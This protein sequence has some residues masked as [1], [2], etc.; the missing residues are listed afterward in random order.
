MYVAMDTQSERWELRRGLLFAPLTIS[1]E[2]IIIFFF[3]PTP[4]MQQHTATIPITKPLYLERKSDI[5]ES[6]TWHMNNNLNVPEGNS[7][8]ICVCVY[9]RWR[10]PDSME[11]N[12]TPLYAE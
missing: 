11:R 10:T 9:I 8:Y 3:M 4:G 7:L 2:L 6:K 1:K 12:I 5:G